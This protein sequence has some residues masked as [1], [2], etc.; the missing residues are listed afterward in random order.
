MSVSKELRI[1]GGSATIQNKDTGSCFVEA[2]YIE[3]E[4]V[5]VTAISWTSSLQLLFSSVHQ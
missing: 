1:A 4:G 2:P 3:F 5:K